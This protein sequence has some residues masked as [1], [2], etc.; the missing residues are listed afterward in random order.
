M[1]YELIKTNPNK[2]NFSRND[3]VGLP[4][5]VYPEL[6]ERTRNDIIVELKAWLRSRASNLGEYQ[7]RGKT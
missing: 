2:A 1:N 5:G 3:K 4:R 6:I 7:V